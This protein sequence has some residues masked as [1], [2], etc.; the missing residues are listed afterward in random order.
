MTSR[1]SPHRCELLG[2]LPPIFPSVPAPGSERREGERRGYGM[3][4]IARSAGRS[5]WTSWTAPPRWLRV[6]G[7]FRV[8]GWGGRRGPKMQ[9]GARR[10]A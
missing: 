6:G 8:A 4:T 3:A 7:R 1:V 9:N 2:A 5:A 10:G